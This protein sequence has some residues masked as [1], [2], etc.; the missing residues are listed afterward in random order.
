MLILNRRRHECL[1]IRPKSTPETAL[2]T[3]EQTSPLVFRVCLISSGASFARI[4]IDVPDS[5]EII[6]AELLDG[7]S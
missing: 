1:V 3:Q 4:G 7:S 2:A 6:R 5:F